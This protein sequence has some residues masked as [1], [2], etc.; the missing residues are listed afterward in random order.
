MS[1]ACTAI[2]LLEC[3]GS[4]LKNC[5]QIQVW[6]VTMT[7]IYF[8]HASCMPNSSARLLPLTFSSTV[9]VMSVQNTVVTNAEVSQECLLKHSRRLENSVMGHLERS[10]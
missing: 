1:Y 10:E 8:L 6:L 5:G 9:L 2:Y 7:G 4:N 3:S